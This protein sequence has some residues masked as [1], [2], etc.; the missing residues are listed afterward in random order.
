MYEHSLKAPLILVGPGI[1][2][3]ETR[4]ELVYLQDVMPTSLELAGLT[5][6]DT[7]EFKSLLPLVKQDAN[8]QRRSEALGAYL[9]CQR[10]IRVKNE[11][12]IVY[13]GSKTIRYFNLKNDPL[14]KED[15]AGD[16]THRKRM[17]ELLALMKVKL[18]EEGDP[19]DL[20]KLNL[21]A[22]N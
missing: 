15:L 20:T 2:K 7:V 8:A 14:E 1:P 10:M 4:E 3:N 12:L 19:L 6:P 11:K 5:P 17:A 22:L 9:N 21:S 18:K 13:P 16:A